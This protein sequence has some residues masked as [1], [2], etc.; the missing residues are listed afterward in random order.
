MTRKELYDLVWSNSLVALCKKYA[1]SDNGLRKICQRMQI[2]LPT[3]GLWM[4]LQFG[5]KVKVFLLSEDET[6]DQTVTLQL[7]VQGN[8][9]STNDPI[10][11]LAKEIQ[12]VIPESLVSPDELVVAAQ[13]V[14]TTKDKYIYNGTLR[15]Y[16]DVL[17]INVSPAGV[18]RALLLFDVLIKTLRRRGHGILFKNGE[19]FAEVKGQNQQIKLR[20]QTKRVKGEDRYAEYVPTGIFYFKI[21]RYPDKEFKDGSRKLEAK[22]AD[23]IAWMEVQAD[24]DN[25]RD[26]QWRIKREQE[27]LEEERLLAIALER[28]REMQRYRDLVAAAERWKQAGLIR[29]YVSAVGS[30]DAEWVGWARK[31]ADWVDP[32]VAAEDG[33]LGRYGEKC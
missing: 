29:E 16:R 26:E 3:N 24:K 12:V 21:D 4:K 23:I 10:Q 6:V 30:A 19:T 9:D 32:V 1:I 25:D 22:M 17:D 18:S 27:K 8:D 11:R 28:D 2:P 31:K 33:V 15:T 7:R 13:K 20:E 14:L 5:K